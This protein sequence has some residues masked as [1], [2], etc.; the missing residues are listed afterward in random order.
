MKQ[1]SFSVIV[2]I[3]NRAHLIGECI[4]SVLAQT[5][6]DFELI[7]VDN[8]STDD[9]AA[10]LAPY[11][12]ERIVMTTC[13]IQGPAAARMKGVSISRGTFLSFLDSDDIWRDDVLQSV[14]RELTSDTKPVAVYIFPHRFQTGKGLPWGTNSLKPDQTTANFVEGMLAGAPGACGLA[15][16]HRELFEGEAGFNESLW[17]GE[18]LDWALRKAELGPIRLLQS[19]ARLAYRR[20]EGNLTQNRNRYVTWVFELH[21]FA[22]SGHYETANDPTLRSFIVNHMMIQLRTLVQMQKFV[23]F[24]RILPRTLALGIRWRVITPAWTL[25]LARTA[26]R[27]LA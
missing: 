13:Q 7:L 15:G 6:T 26:L 24:I 9:L 18:D 22:E 4:Q 23:Q 27:K 16:V 2:P 3:H 14:H 19:E 21:E 1:P 8:N 5:F 10:A 11:S 12:D 20:H 25:R 17:V